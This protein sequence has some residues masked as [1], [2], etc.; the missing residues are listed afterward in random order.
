MKETTLHRMYMNRIA[1]GGD[2]VRYM[3]PGDRGYTPVTF[4]QVGDAA[5]EIALGLMALG[6]S[7]GDRVA[8]LATTRLE[9]CLADIGSTLGGFV[10]V[11]IYPS[12][13]PDQVE[14]ILAHS[15]ARAVFVED[16]P[17][18]NKVAG[19]RSRLP[20]LASVV[21][22]TG[23]VEG[24]E[25]ASTFAALR[26][27]GKAHGSS[28]P[29]SLEARAEEI[30]PTDDLT[31]I[32]TSGTTGPPK[33]VVTRHSNYAFNVTSALEAVNVPKG[34]MF[35][36]FL[37]LAHSLGRLEHFLAFDAMAVSSFARS[38]QTVAEDL[39]AVRPEIMVSVPRL[40][41]KF[42][43]RV[44]AKVEEDGGLKKAIFEWALG[45]GREASRCRQ[46]GGEPQGLL[47]VKN[48]IADKLVFQKI[49]ARMG[50]RLRFFISGGAP[51]SREIAEFLH[52]IGVLILEGYGLT[53]TSTV[54]TVNRLERYKFGTVGKALPGTEIRIA[55]DGEI[56]V[57]G[58]HIFREYFNDPAATREA[59]EPDGWFHTGDI[60]ALDEE[61]FL[62]I[63][64]RKKD[65]IVTSGGKNIAPQ[66]LEN[67]LK[68]DRYVSQ[69][70]V[71][72][73]RKKYLTALL[74]LSPEEI[75]AWAAKQGIP[76]RSVEALAKHPQVLQ[77]MRERVDEVNR[78]LASFEQVKKFAVLETDFSQE[79]GEL[80]PTL[81]V[82]RK[83]VIEKYGR[84]LDDL[85]GKD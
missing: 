70:F 25:G 49:R 29:G 71:F 68:N 21:M 76:D 32:Y 56:L 44:L 10:T 30:L 28:N 81:K 38:L 47:A 14:Y 26:E 35:L 58:K 24:K 74:T 15:R 16:E 11:P 3:V 48:R 54:T 1:E 69:A 80:T 40:Y 65:I 45:V 53:E 73:D 46:Q 8:I 82:R 75:V 61:G 52:A 34:A 9:W 4:R 79:T 50:G 17:Q 64:D 63:T 60:G 33:G 55:A 23:G 59:I 20:H 6:L 41:E 31:I 39:A 67:L 18:Y 83:V 2:S 78:G 77:L 36:Q 42:Y 12:N 22:M 62:R 13:L 43:A 37:P 27:R 5:R 19:V 72:G 66:N 85:Y 57:R 51:L 84:I 7:K